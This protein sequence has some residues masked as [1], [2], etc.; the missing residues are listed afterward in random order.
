MRLV[1]VKE[2]KEIELAANQAGMSNEEMMQSAGKGIADFLNEQFSE[3]ENKQVIGLI[4][5]GNNG[6]D[7][8]IALTSLLRSGWQAAA[9]TIN[10]RK[11]DPLVKDFI[12]EG[13]QLIE[14]TTEV[15]PVE[16]KE[17]LTSNTV[18]LDG[19]LGTGFHLP[20]KDEYK[21]YLSLVKQSLEQEQI[22]V[23]VD[24]PSGMDC[25]TGEKANEIIPADITLCL[26]AVKIGLLTE[27]AFLSCGEIYTIPLN[28]SGEADKLFNEKMVID[29]EWA[30][31]HFPERSEFSHKGTFGK[32]LVIGGS[33]NYFGAPLLA[34]T[35]AYRTGCGLVTLA[36]PHA[37]AVVM[38]S[39]TPEI[40][41][42]NLD[43]EDG[44]IA[45]SAAD[46]ALKKVD[47]YSCL[48]I[49][50]GIGTEETTGHFLEKLLFQKAANNKR[51]IGFLEGEISSEEQSN[52]PTAVIDADALRW[53]AESNDW[54]ARVKTEL[55]L[56]P[57]PGEMAV[58]TGISV[59]EIQKDR[60]II[61]AHFAEKWDQVVVLKGA[62]TVIAA[63]DGR[64]AVIPVANSALAK[65]GSG[66]VLTGIIS[67]LVAQGLARYEAACLGA[68][69]HANAGLAAIELLGSSASVM[70]TDV[71]SCISDVLS[72]LE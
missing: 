7:T 45:E 42:L 23:A 41:W 8:L 60:L 68:W 31:S 30:S 24:C 35:A 27:S 26:E 18:I 12:Q 34:G 43:D 14:F 61:A 64:L 32:V 46:L 39:R 59:K 58:L 54:A 38:A 5:K 50:P 3:T 29:M 56:T 65:A 69:I 25:D 11:G 51:R 13:G 17:F 47:D 2:M 71:I 10:T 15:L 21:S 40:T 57:H 22:I 20:L 6:G 53:L 52:L 48:A 62:L 66:D 28:L 36:V 55:V 33:T 67:S 1:T 9:F 16:F 44:V 19:L 72:N 63:P 70:A 4:G 37:V 49:G